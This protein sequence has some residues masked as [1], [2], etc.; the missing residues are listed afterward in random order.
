[1][2]QWLRIFLPMKGD[3]RDAVS[4]PGWGQFPGG[5]N[6]NPLHYSYQDDLRE[7]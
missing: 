6:D 1:M 4:I 7:A 5:G 3:T 2:A